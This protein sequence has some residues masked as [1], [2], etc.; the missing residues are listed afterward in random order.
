MQPNHRHQNLKKN[1]VVR[2]TKTS[3]KRDN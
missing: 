1:S 3:G 2:K